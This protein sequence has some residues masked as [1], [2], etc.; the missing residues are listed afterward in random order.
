MT[1]GNAIDAASVPE[2][3]QPSPVTTSAAG[4]EAA[5]TE[6]G[7]R[8]GWLDVLRGVAALAVVFDHLS[9][10]VLQHVRADIYHW[11]DP[12]NYG[13]FVFFII[14]GYIVPASLERKGSVRTFWV[15]RLF[16]LYPLY[17][18]AVG[19]AV[20]LYLV[21][22]G[23][24]RGENSDPTAS[25]LSQLLMMSNVLGGENL[26]NVVWSL[27]Y[28][29]VFYLLLTALFIARV[30]KRSSWYGLGFAVAAV[31][32]G[33]LLPQA[34][35]THNVATPRL[36]ALVADLAVLAG[37]AFAV[38]LRGMS[39]LLGA[40]I[41]AV[42]AVALLAFNGGWIWPWEALSILALMFTG[43]VF[44]RADQGQYPW[45]KAIPVGVAVLGL[46]IAAG[47][48]HSHAWGMSASAEL[49]WERRWF[50]ALALAGLTFGAGLALRH[51]RWPA[52]MTWL[53]LISFSV[54]L[55]H[56]LL[57][58]VYHHFT[59]TH[60]HHPFWLQVLLASAVLAVTIAV[61]SVTYL[62]V[63]RP[64][65]QVGRR[66][67]HWLDTRFGP[68]RAPGPVRTPEPAMAGGANPT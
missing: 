41:A 62:L 31:A 24:I 19:I 63:E 4:P 10:Y 8:L 52:W 60:R 55:L 33:G 57:I 29:M 7:R 42:V 54:Y 17:L 12:G 25:I 30:H 32:I 46:T 18:L 14:S 15:S 47:L 59:W 6:P 20:A 38:V 66:V 26:P 9:Y 1:R 44:Y 35:L 40:A 21:H 65:Q 28:E 58:E 37:L 5:R 48:W 43:T 16:R 39:R 23:S 64:M 11:F 67:G 50:S 34:F 68:D 3:R 51:V 27:S 36:I 53:G 22:F 49:T 56:P 61:S 13:V 2:P 45:R